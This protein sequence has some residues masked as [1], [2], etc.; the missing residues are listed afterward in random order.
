MATPVTYKGNGI[1]QVMSTDEFTGL[2]H[3]VLEYMATEN[4][5]GGIYNT[6]EGGSSTLI[7]TFTDTAYAGELG[8]ANVTILST[9]FPLYQDL[10]LPVDND[11]PRPLTYVSQ[12]KPLQKMNDQQLDAM[13]DE[14][15]QYCVLQEG[16]HSFQLATDT[17]LDGGTWTSIGT[18]ID[19]EFEGRATNYNLYKKLSSGLTS[20]F[21]PIKQLTQ[22]VLQLFTDEDVQLIAKIVRERIVNTGIGQYVLQATAPTSGTW[23]N[24]GTI[25]NRISTLDATIFDT[26]Y[27]G[28]ESYSASGLVA[29]TEAGEDTGTV[30]AGPVRYTGNQVVVG[31]AEYTREDEAVV[32]E[33]Y[34]QEYLALPEVNYVNPVP[35]Y[36]L[37]PVQYA[38]DIYEGSYTGPTVIGFGN[39]LVYD[40][41]YDANLNYESGTN[42]WS[43]IYNLNPGVVIPTPLNYTGT[44]IKYTADSNNYT[45]DIGYI[46]DA[47]IGDVHVY[48]ASFTA[49]FDGVTYV[50]PT[51]SYA[52]SYTREVSSEP[53]INNSY[54]RLIYDAT[55]NFFIANQNYTSDV[56]YHGNYLGGYYVLTYVNPTPREGPSYAGRDSVMDLPFPIYYTGMTALGAGYFQLGP[57]STYTT[58]LKYEGT[59]SY[60]AA[61]T[62]E[63][64]TYTSEYQ[65]FAGYTAPDTFVYNTEFGLIYDITF[66]GINPYYG[67][68]T[69]D[70]AASYLGPTGTYDNRIYTSFA[71]YNDWKPYVGTTVYNFRAYEQDKDYTGTY[72]A[73][74]SQYVTF[75][76]FIGVYEESYLGIVSYDASV[77]IYTLEKNVFETL[78]M[79]ERNESPYPDTSVV[80]T[81]YPYQGPLP[82]T[83]SA[84]YTDTALMYGGVYGQNTYT[85]EIGNEY[86]A[87]Y[88]SQFN[89]PGPTYVGPTGSYEAFFNVNSTTTYGGVY[90]RMDL[91]EDVAY[92]TNLPLEYTADI[93]SYYSAPGS[94]YGGYT[95]DIVYNA[96]IGSALDYTGSSIYGEATYTDDI[97]VYYTTDIYTLEQ[98][99]AVDDAGA[100][101]TLGTG[102]YAGPGG[103]YVRE[104][105]YTSDFVVFNR[106]TEYPYIAV[107]YY[108]GAILQ[109][110][111]Y[112]SING[113]FLGEQTYASPAGDYLSGTQIFASG[114]IANY[115]G[116]RVWDTYTSTTLLYSTYTN[117]E[118]SYTGAFSLTTPYTSGTAVFLSYSDGM[119]Y[120]SST[121][122]LS[123]TNTALQY[124]TAYSSPES[125][126]LDSDFYQGQGVYSGDV[127]TEF[128]TATYATY[129][130]TYYIGSTYINPD[131]EEYQGDYTRTT[132]YT[133]DAQDAQVYSAY[134]QNYYTTFYTTEGIFSVS[135]VYTGDPVYDAEYVGTVS[136][137]NFYTQAAY[138]VSYESVAIYIAPG[139]YNTYNGVD[140]YYDTRPIFLGAARYTTTYHIEEYTADIQTEYGGQ[141]RYGELYVG[142]LVNYTGDTALYI[143]SYYTLDYTGGDLYTADLYY[144]NATSFDA[145]Y[146]GIDSFNVIDL[147]YYAGNTPYTGPGT[148]YYES[149][150]YTSTTVTYINSVIYGSFIGTLE[151]TSV[152]IDSYAGAPT[153]Y[154][155][156]VTNYNLGTS[157]T[158]RYTAQYLIEDYTGVSFTRY[159]APAAYYDS[160]DIYLRSLYTTT[161][162]G[163][164]YYGRGGAYVGPAVSLFTDDGAQYLGA[165]G[166]FTVEGL[167][168]LYTSQAYLGE[169]STY[170][171]FGFHRE[172][173]YVGLSDVN[174]TDTSYNSASFG[175]EI[176]IY[177]GNYTT[178]NTGTEYTTNLAG[179][180]TPYSRDSVYTNEL[181]DTTIS[182]VLTD[183]YLG[184]GPNNTIPYTLDVIQEY[185]GVGDR[186]YLRDT[187][188]IAEYTLA[189]VGEGSLEVD[190]KTLWR[191]VA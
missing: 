12:S 2:A 4:G 120:T 103:T 154:V 183:I 83:G 157:F 28:V 92:Y 127:E 33:F 163:E 148:D 179:V 117:T 94:L 128:V 85:D 35:G 14:I 37:G 115:V 188:Y 133:S 100:V 69:T 129:A 122:P 93:A 102:N 109:P 112:V 87:V 121:I 111:Y 108:T 32:S 145:V 1:I 114:G 191:R 107:I 8:D 57:T 15:L 170:S 5:P 29:Y 67:G 24:K 46:S 34:A 40:A 9:E 11:P 175:V 39:E 59:G 155:G 168:Q 51:G 141:P 38:A 142:A 26:V 76:N 162:V 43:A 90:S 150:D 143:V 105:L 161:Y 36:Y 132:F 119:A 23:V 134:Q 13:A 25:T 18:L 123:Y 17:P 80:G 20:S 146:Q 53:Y 99:Y 63:I 110:G 96:Q 171:G 158:G 70:T 27:G 167:P 52:L 78:G 30:Y 160:A 95:T 75:Q 182:F 66:D 190:S 176:P 16:P 101:Y 172:T 144:T 74:Y 153:A 152:G 149:N 173:F 58:S 136:F 177:S 185:T 169:P 79:Y 81:I 71:A 126:T 49:E 56:T 19:K 181:I 104:G 44:E 48:V 116:A 140:A 62:G 65:A 91:P 3:S 130:S 73:S 21:K 166:Y 186:E 106:D 124:T 82:Y 135:V 42:T 89:D 139:V 113:E 84:I 137:N 147:V 174:T 54:D 151:Y 159:A 184:P 47:Y 31:G 98:Y 72:L 6:N 60:Y 88:L 125:Y 41:F 64:I 164:E 61:Y 187:D 189:L 7:G 77:A 68:Y 10:N 138:Q 156:S 86:S 180:N 97:V 45:G 131:N 22:G 178:D 50:G 165:G 118:L 55:D